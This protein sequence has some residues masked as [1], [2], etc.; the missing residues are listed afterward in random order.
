VHNVYKLGY[1]WVLS[2]GVCSCGNAR[3]NDTH[4]M[5]VT[6]LSYMYFYRYETLPLGS[7]LFTDICWTGSTSIHTGMFPKLF[8][9]HTN[10]GFGK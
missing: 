1:M 7:G 4:E 9:S 10:F 8:C 3:I 5:N 2:G 6:V